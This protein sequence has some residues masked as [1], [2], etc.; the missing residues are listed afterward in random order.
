MNME[1]EL[2]Q[3]E[4]GLDQLEHAW[5]ELVG[6]SSVD[7]PFLQWDWCSTWWRHYSRDRKLLVVL[8]RHDDR[9]MG[10]APLFVGRS[11]RVRPIRSVCFLGTGE[12]CSEYL[13]F[14][15]RR[16]FEYEVTEAILDFLYGE[17]DEWDEI[18]L[19]AVQSDSALA[20]AMRRYWITRGLLFAES[21]GPLCWQA[22]LPANWDEFMVALPKKRRHELRRYT[23]RVESHGGS[24]NGVRTEEELRFAWNELKRLHQV[25]WNGAGQPGCFVSPQFAA[26]HDE[27]LPRLFRRSELI[28]NVLKL[29]HE[30]AAVNQSFRHA[31][32]VYSYQCGRDPA[33]AQLAPGQTLRFFEFRQAVER[34]DR[35]Y[36]FLGGSERYKLDWS[37][38]ACATSNFSAPALGWGRRAEFLVTAG[39]DRFKR[40]SR[41]RLPGRTWEGLQKV[42]HALVGTRDDR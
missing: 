24:F 1:I 6:A 3:D 2:V 25:R 7:H 11:G 9:L 16:G 14:I 4:A 19:T 18:R 23:R 33:R 36:D 22:Q 28:L 40:F 5:Q 27:L 31:G 17:W 41:A 21:P 32:V 39:L 30:A 8:A 29:G 20:D 37:T 10:I 35:V 38:R 13:G 34:G 15:C 42:H 26:F 12:I